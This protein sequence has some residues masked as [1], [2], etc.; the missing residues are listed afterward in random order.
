[1]NKTDNRTKLHETNEDEDAMRDLE[2]Q[3]MQVSPKP[4]S[5]GSQTNIKDELKESLR[6]D[7]FFTRRTDP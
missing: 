6:K 3:V 1:L 4:S 5:E 2:K 7:N